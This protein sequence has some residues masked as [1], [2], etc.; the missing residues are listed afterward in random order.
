MSVQYNNT[1]IQYGLSLYFVAQRARIQLSIS[2]KTQ[3][4]ILGILFAALL[5]AA[6]SC[7]GSGNGSRLS[8]FPA[9]LTDPQREI[10][11][12]YPDAWVEEAGSATLE[13]PSGDQALAVRGMVPNLG[14]TNFQTTVEL[15]VDNKS[16]GTKTV[17]PGNFQFSARVPSEPGKHRIAVA[18]SPLQELPAGDGRMVGARLQFLGFEPAGRQ[19]SSGEIVRGPGVELGR[20]W[21]VVETFRGETFRWVDNDAQIRLT[22]SHAGDALLSLVVEPGPGEG[23]KPFLLKAL[24]ESGHQ[25]AAVRVARRG[26]VK[27]FVPVVSDKPNEFRLHADGGG[28]PAKNDPRILNFRVFQ[29]GVDPAHRP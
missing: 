1:Q 8:R 17:G 19:A 28:K 4:G 20:G 3:P 14:N 27:L 21:G 26:T 23:G 9:D 22:A 2:M 6:A 13:Q 15:R 16:I 18:F 29:I 10:S 7:G 12:I 5:L 11:G 24:D 25:V